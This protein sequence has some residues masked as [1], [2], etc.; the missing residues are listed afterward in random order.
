MKTHTLNPHQIVVVCS[1]DENYAMPMTAT[2]RSALSNLKNKRSKILLFVLDGGIKAPT[3]RKV[4]ASLQSAQIEIHW[5]M[6]D[7]AKVKGLPESKYITIASYYRLLM[8]ELLPQELDKAIYL[9]SDM[10]VLGDLQELWDMELADYSVLAVSNGN[11]IETAGGL[12]NYKELG[13]NPE[14]TYF[15]A[16]LLVV[17]LRKW[18]DDN[19]GFKFLEFIE[20][21]RSIIQE[22]DQDALNAVL[23][24]KWGELNPRWN[25]LP[26]IHTVFSSWES[27]PFSDPETYHAVRNDPLIIH[28]AGAKPWHLTCNH[29]AVDIFEQY[30]D[31]TAWAGTRDTQ[32]KRA[33]RKLKRAFRQARKLVS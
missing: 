25:Q 8:A 22:H 6:P 33:Q 23:E 16:G 3:K 15:N 13:L 31:Q 28:Y 1:A 11:K 30:L 32:L 7:Q 29:P 26:Q 5:L 18:R 14:S 17:N 19:I 9:D 10:I 12:R 2:V 21:N 24:G 4:E 20:K 27:S